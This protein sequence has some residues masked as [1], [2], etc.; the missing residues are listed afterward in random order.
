MVEENQIQLESYL[1]RLDWL[2]KQLQ[3][4]NDEIE[5]NEWKSNRK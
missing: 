4:L 1:F 5:F 2:K 3:S